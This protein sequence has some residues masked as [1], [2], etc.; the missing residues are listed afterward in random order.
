MTSQFGLNQEV[1]PRINNNYKRYKGVGAGRN[2]ARIEVGGLLD[3]GINVKFQMWNAA[4]LKYVFGSV[5]GV[6]S[7]G[8]RCGR[9]G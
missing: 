5:T 6:G 8:D 7:A 1:T 4:F 3:A 2:A 9:S